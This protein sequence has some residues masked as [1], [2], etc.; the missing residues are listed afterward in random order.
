MDL[1]PRVRIV[2]DSVADI[3]PSLAAEMGI[4]VVPASIIFG[5]ETYLEGIDLSREDFYTRL[6]AFKGLPKTA[7]AGPGAF[8]DAFRQVIAE[9]SRAGV[10]LEGIVSLHPPVA[11]SG[12]YNSA[13]GASQMISGTRIAV[14]DSGQITMGTGLMAIVACRAAQAGASMDEVVALVD[15]IKP[16]TEII[17]GLETLEWAARSGRINRLVASLG[18][19]LAVKPILDV[20][21]GEITLPERVRTHSRQFERVMEIARAWAPYRE[22]AV[23]HARAPEVAEAAAERMADV[24]PRQRMIVAE[25][26]CALGSYVGP[27]AFG[28]VAIRQ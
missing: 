9:N 14:I 18:N 10:P 23:V 2:T 6:V 11:L 28:I 1:P 15:A 26:G 4:P 24:F 20:R 22:V 25:I 3:P 27:G 17:A 13:Y 16:R 7:S 5:N 19:L 21:G 8:A 12:L